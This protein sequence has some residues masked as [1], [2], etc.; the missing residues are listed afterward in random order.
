MG[1]SDQHAAA[2]KYEAITASLREQAAQIQE[3][4]APSLKW[5]SLHHKQLGTR[6]K[7]VGLVKYWEN[8][9]DRLSKAG[10][11]GLGLSH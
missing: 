1:G 11:S 10:S 5:I 9:A 3:S 7:G 2:A 6:T 8:I 4:E